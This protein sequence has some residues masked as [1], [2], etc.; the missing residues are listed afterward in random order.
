MRKTAIV[1]YVMHTLHV[2]LIP[3]LTV[4]Q[5]QLENTESGNGNENGNGNVNW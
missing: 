3:E 5:G 1:V 2:N 4:N